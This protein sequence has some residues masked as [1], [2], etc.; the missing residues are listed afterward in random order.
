MLD[1]AEARLAQP[2]GFIC[3]SDLTRA[4]TL[5]RALEDPG[6]ACRP[7]RKPRAAALRRALDA[8]CR[9]RFQIDLAN[10]LLRQLPQLSVDT[11]D[12]VVADLEAAALDLRRLEAV[13]R[14][15]GVPA[16]YDRALAEAGGALLKLAH[17]EAR[18]VDLAR[19]SEILLGPEA[20]LAVLDGGRP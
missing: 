17:P 19:L 3:V 2:R 15:L 11:P 7:S 14:A 8:H 18:R 16:H 13:G 1:Q 9:D 4:A 6:P 5:I 12:D 20:G 10:R